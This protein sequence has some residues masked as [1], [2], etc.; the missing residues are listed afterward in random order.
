MQTTLA[1]GWILNQLM[2][3]DVVAGKMNSEA[4]IRNWAW[5]VTDTKVSADDWKRRFEKMKAS[6][7]DAVLPQIYASHKAFFASSR[8]PIE[9]EWLELLLPLAQDAGLECHA[10]MWSMPCNNP[11]IL[12]EHPEWYVVNAKGESAR[13]KPAYVPYYK[14]MC[15]SRPGVREFVSGT[16]RELSSID[17]LSG[18]H[19]DYIRFPDVILPEALQPK[20]DIVQDRE[21]PQYDYCYCDK[22]CDGFASESGL[23]AR[24]LKDDNELD[25]WKAYRASLITALV[26]DHLVPVAREA[27][28]EIT[29]AVFPNWFHVRQKWWEWGLD[30]VLPML[31]H[32]FYNEEIPWIGEM[33]RS[34]IER[35]PA[36]T[37]YYSGLFVPHISPENMSLAYTTALDAG[38]KGISLFN[39][40]SMSDAHW[41]RL[42]DAVREK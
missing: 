6:G 20:Y 18:V 12:E 27:G 10:W 32:G 33:T 35:L 14:F 3:G 2:G 38:A 40:S 4:K 22:C 25:R 34:G 31:Y 11:G 15:P 7:I 17:G 9:S 19:L 36:D 39:S 23:D 29:A 13:D 37:P 8:L 26:R 16:V 1:S 41:D 42:A 24:N 30:A 28:K 5:I 21:Y